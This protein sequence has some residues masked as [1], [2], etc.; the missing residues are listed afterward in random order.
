MTGGERAI[1]IFG[2]IMSIAITVT[3]ALWFIPSVMSSTSPA[4]AACNADPACQSMG[5]DVGSTELLFGILFVGGI[6]ESFVV[7]YLLR[8]SPHIH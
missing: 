4:A 2:L 6:V 3:G 7:A 5:P 8:T 1:A